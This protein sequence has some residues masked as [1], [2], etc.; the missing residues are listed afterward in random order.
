M[1]TRSPAVLE[2]LK[3]AVAG[4]AATWAMNRATTWLYERQPREA[5]E[6]ENEARGGQ[7]AYA[8][9]AESLA[10][11]TGLELD[12]NQKSTAAS[13]I[14]WA[15]G[16]IAGMKYAVLRH[17]WPGVRAGG[18]TLYGT[19]FFL[20]M[21]EMM[22]P[23]LGLTP[24]PQRFPWQ[25]HARG[26]AG[27]LVFGIVSDCALR[28]LDRLGAAEE[29]ADEGPYFHPTGIEEGTW[30]AAEHVRPAGAE[31]MEDVWERPA[32]RRRG[33][34]EHGGEH[35]EPDQQRDAGPAR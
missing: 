23:A 1:N 20:V 32:P 35:A 25:T 26:L 33:A 6:R 16:I 3:G 27:H 29:D 13:T 2:I 22:N 8:T 19:G 30:Q 15:T 18:G 4:A 11:R 10:A 12:E 24:G 28:L 14:H 17:L 34:S 31:N 7:S 5:R 9:A 21:D